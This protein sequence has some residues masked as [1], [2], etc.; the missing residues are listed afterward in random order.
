MISSTCRAAKLSPG[1]E[2]GIGQIDGQQVGF[3]LNQP[4]RVADCLNPDIGGQVCNE[5]SRQFR[6]I[7]ALQVVGNHLKVV[8]EQKACHVL[9]LLSPP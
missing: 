5:T 1:Q 9:I 7:Q 3:H 6:G 8:G 2:Y 4:V